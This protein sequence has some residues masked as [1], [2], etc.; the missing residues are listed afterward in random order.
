MPI[1][2]HGLPKELLELLILQDRD[3]NVCARQEGVSARCACMQGWATQQHCAWQAAL[4][5]SQWQ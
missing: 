4:M 1:I 5:W 2:A 3:R